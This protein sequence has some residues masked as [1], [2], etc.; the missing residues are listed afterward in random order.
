VTAPGTRLARRLVVV[1]LCACAAAWRETAAQSAPPAPPA[2]ASLAGVVRDTAGVPIP[3][4]EI[5]VRDVGKTVRAGAGGAFSVSDVAPGTHEVWFRRLG[6][7]SVEYNWKARAGERTE[8]A[9]TLHAIARALD[10]VVVRAEEDRRMRGTSSILGMVVDTS[11]NPID[12]AEVQLVGAD[13]IAVTRAN[14]GFLF[15]PLPVGTYLVKVRKLG[16]SPAMM[17]VGLEDHDDRQVLLR[18]TPLSAQLDP[19]IIAERSGYGADQRVYDELDERMRW[20]N[21][22]SVVL[23]RDALERFHGWSLDY[24]VGAMGVAGLEILA[25]RRAARGP[26]SINPRGTQQTMSG[27]GAGIADVCILLDGKTQIHQP[28][29]AFSTADLEMIEIYPSGTEVTGTISDRM[30]GPCKA[31]SLLAHPTYYVLWERR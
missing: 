17:T 11:G 14:G 27:V 6:Y 30:S 1:T 25:Q 26:R 13:R 8:I 21:F 24:A 29:S 9:V 10:P 16:Y 5:I 4:A 20:H 28:L 22:K 15:R 12:E 3:D 18:I 19:M 31:Q 23:G 7:T 2:P